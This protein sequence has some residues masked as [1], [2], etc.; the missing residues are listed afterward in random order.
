METCYE[1][2]EQGL[3]RKFS[4][5]PL[6]FDVRIAKTSVRRGCAKIPV[7]QSVYIP[8]SDNPICISSIDTPF[9]HSAIVNVSD[10]SVVLLVLVL[11]RQSD[12]Y[13]SGQVIGFEGSRRSNGF[14]FCP[15]TAGRL[16]N[17]WY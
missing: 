15:L 4:T 11:F 2:H 7:P 6:L 10:C 3:S 1:K 17:D 9:H 8:R 16:L 12:H 13:A 5:Q 14:P